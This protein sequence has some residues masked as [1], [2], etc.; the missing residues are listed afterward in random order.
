MGGSQRA[1]SQANST[2]I[3]AIV[4]CTVEAKRWKRDVRDESIYRG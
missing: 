3:D 1:V 2:K 4:D